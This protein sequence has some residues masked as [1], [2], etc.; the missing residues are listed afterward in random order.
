[1]ADGASTDASQFASQEATRLELNRQRRA[2]AE[3]PEDDEGY[4]GDSA[5]VD[6][7]VAREGRE[8]RMAS[9]LR[10]ARGTNAP[11]NSAQGGG[12]S[13]GQSAAGALG[14]A[15]GAV[16]GAAVGA[17]PQAMAT[18]QA[19]TQI[20][21]TLWGTVWPSFGHTIYIIDLLHYIAPHWS[22]VRKFWPESRAPLKYAEIVG[23]V[24]VTLLVIGLDLL[25][26]A[27]IVVTVAFF[28]S[29][30]GA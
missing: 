30:T 28:L 26:I 21:K 10:M 16:A 27:S 29:L 17:D 4:G 14:P 9:R 8:E 1:M 19:G 5:A 11:P 24:V 2:H 7:A 20:K 13:L 6:Q 25:L 22:L 23:M 15:G 18:Q 3:S 12:A